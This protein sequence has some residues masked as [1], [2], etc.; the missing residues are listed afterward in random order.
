[1]NEGG[2][3]AQWLQGYDT[4]LEA[5]RTVMATLS[6]VFAVV[7]CWVTE[8]VDLLF[9][10]SLRPITYDVSA[11][12]QRLQEEPFQTAVEKTWR[13][14][15]LEGVFARYLARADFCQQVAQS[16]PV[17]NTDDRTVLEFAYARSLG[18]GRVDH[19]S[20]LRIAALQQATH[21]PS[22]TN[23]QV[24]WR[25]VVQQQ[26]SAQVLDNVAP[27]VPRVGSN[28]ISRAQAKVQY[29]AEDLEEA[30]QYWQAQPDEPQDLVEWTMVAELLA[31]AGEAEAL[32]YLEK[33]RRHE[34]VEADALLAR[35]HWRNGDAEK[36][37]AALEAAF[38]G[39]RRDPW[40]Q[41]RLMR[42]ALKLAEEIAE[43]DR[44]PLAKRLCSALETP[45]ALHCENFHRIWARLDTA[46]RLDGKSFSAQTLAA[47]EA[48]EPF[49]P[50]TRDFL[51]L[52]Q[53]CY[54]E[55]RHPQAARAMADLESFL[56]YEPRPLF[57]E[58]PEEEEEQEASGP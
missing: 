33:L 2:L 23:G 28:A 12:R 13:V 9:L 41:P 49:A 19:L 32:P 24:N 4:D 27:E 34:P 25:R 56:R 39:Y 53:A 1:L 20:T 22:L 10:A 26:S 16:A 55:N 47:I 43:E 38:T 44:G 52:R 36:A 40:P 11:L 21:Q 57:P 31:E 58:L 37:T 14:T 17:L 18:S 50:W 35:F 51:E 3:F 46:R 15:D 42:R 45:F 29:V 5:L 30:L 54:E 7:E 48:F 8:D 6:S